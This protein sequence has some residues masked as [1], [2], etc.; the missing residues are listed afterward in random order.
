VVQLSMSLWHHACLPNPLSL[1]LQSDITA[2]TFEACPGLCQMHPATP[3]APRASLSTFYVMS[4][5]YLQVVACCCPSC[6]DAA[7]TRSATGTVVP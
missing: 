1:P 5:P 7:M 2:S 6:I 3:M 4:N